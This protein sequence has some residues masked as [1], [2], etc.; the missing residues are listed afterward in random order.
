MFECVIDK[1][2]FNQ[3]ALVEWQIRIGEVEFNWN[4]GWSLNVK[5]TLQLNRGILPCRMALNFLSLSSA[6]APFSA[7][8][9]AG[10][11]V[12]TS[13]MLFC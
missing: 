8:D 5:R 11:S 10:F 13:A 3:R 7:G 1:T 12:A 2:E 6:A 9:A 4:H